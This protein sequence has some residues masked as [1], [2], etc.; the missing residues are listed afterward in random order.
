MK[1]VTWREYRFAD[2][3]VSQVRKY[4]AQELR[5][6]ERKHGKCLSVRIIGQ[7]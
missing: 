3:L 7:F 6:M 1:K 2:G 5:A 4:S